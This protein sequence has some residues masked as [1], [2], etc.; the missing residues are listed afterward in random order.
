M[1]GGIYC[2]HSVYIRIYIVVATSEIGHAFR[3]ESIARIATMGIL[4]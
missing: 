2:L 4:A 1:S 3:R